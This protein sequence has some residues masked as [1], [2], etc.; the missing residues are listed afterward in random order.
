MIEARRG[1]IVVIKNPKFS[2]M[3]G[4]IEAAQED[5]LKIYYP[6]EYEGM[7]WALSVGDELLVDVHTPF[8]VRHMN[9]MVISTPLEDGE[10]VIENASAFQIPQKREF[11]RS[12]VEFN[13]FIKKEDSLIRARCVDISAG[14]IKF[15]PDENIFCEGD[16]VEI[17]FLSDEFEKDI[18][19]KAVIISVKVNNAVALYTDINEFDRDKIA[20]F[21]IKVLDERD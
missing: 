19:V 7:A 12:A 14:G 13:F 10:L 4:I 11:V 3:E 6:K 2:K 1:Q 8:G 17:K 20:K 18:N 15:T 5:R 9:S 21:C 16:G